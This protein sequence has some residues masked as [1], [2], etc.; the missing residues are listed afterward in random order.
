VLFIP[1]NTRAT[2]I[3]KGDGECP[4][5]GLCGSLALPVRV[6]MCDRGLLPLPLPPW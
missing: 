1:V 4:R 5:D 2:F 3:R 6:A